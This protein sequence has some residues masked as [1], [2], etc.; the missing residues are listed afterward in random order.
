MNIL[1]EVGGVLGILQNLFFFILTPISQI[2]FY[3]KALKRL[4]LAT[5]DRDDLFK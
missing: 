3:I 4:Y 1:A 2:S 5:T